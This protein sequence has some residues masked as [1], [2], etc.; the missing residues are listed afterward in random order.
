MPIPVVRGGGPVTG[1]PTK[2]PG[3]EKGQFA[4]NNEPSVH[5]RK[6][7]NNAGSQ[8]RHIFLLI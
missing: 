7:E 8:N 3:L 4:Q 2:I 1:S 5:Q 6:K